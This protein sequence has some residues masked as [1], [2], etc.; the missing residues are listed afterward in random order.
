MVVGCGKKCDVRDPF[1]RARGHAAQGGQARAAEVIMG[2]GVRKD[3]A[4]AETSVVETRGNNGD[5]I[6]ENPGDFARFWKALRGGNDDVTRREKG[7]GEVGLT[8]GSRW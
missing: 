8:G 3:R 2:F 6:T 4:R 7:K 5:E 1:Y